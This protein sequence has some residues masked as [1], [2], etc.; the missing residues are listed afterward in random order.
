MGSHFDQAKLDST[1]ENVREGGGGE[2]ILK[3]WGHESLVPFLVQK[4]STLPG[5]Q[6]SL[7]EQVKAVLLR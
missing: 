3:G 5:L 6:K 4:N 7:I 2:K 1:V